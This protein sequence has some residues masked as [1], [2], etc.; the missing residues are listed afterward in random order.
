MGGSGGE[1]PTFSPCLPLA[2]PYTRGLSRC[3]SLT[4]VR[5][6]RGTEMLRYGNLWPATQEEKE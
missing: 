5:E 3:R 1:P 4:L 2:Q 6:T